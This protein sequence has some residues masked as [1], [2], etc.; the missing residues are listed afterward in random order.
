MIITPFS[1]ELENVFYEFKH[2]KYL[3]KM[4]KKNLELYNTGYSD[5]RRIVGEIERKGCPN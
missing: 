2:R 3:V 4:L 5:E 1:Q